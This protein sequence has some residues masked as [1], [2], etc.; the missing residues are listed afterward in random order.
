MSTQAD[1]LK[2]TEMKSLSECSNKLAT[3]GYTAQFSVNENGELL[4]NDKTYKADDVTIVN[5][6]RFEGFSDPEDNS[7][8]YALE[9]TDGTKG[10]LVDA[11]GAYADP[12]VS[13]FIKNVEEMQKKM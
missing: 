12:N 8:L 6:F 4:A 5:F 1:A 10:T 11:Y 7:I 3:Q 2:F 9:A 13:N